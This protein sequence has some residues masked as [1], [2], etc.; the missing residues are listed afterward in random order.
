[1]RRRHGQLGFGDGLVA[2]RRRGKDRLGEIGRLVDW[3]AF[4]DVLS[5]IHASATGAPGYAPLTMFKVLLLQQWYRL[6]DP[7][8]E[9]ALDDRLSFLRFV[10]LS[11]EDAV[12]DHS[13]IS[14]FRSHLIA[15]GL[16]EPLFAE[17][18][19]QLMSHRLIVRKGTLIDASVVQAAAAQPSAKQG[20]R[21]TVDPEAAWARKGNRATFGYKMHIAV[22]RGSLL[23]RRRDLTPGNRNDC[24]PA[25]GLICG[26]EAAVYADKAYD[27]ATLRQALAR[28]NIRNRIMQRGNKHHALPPAA[29]RRN[30]RLSPIRAPV[31]AVFGTLK[32]HYRMARLRYHG[33]VRN[34]L[35]LT[36]ACMAFNLR[37]WAVIAAT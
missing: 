19:R 25:A 30:R 13:T 22:D 15:H 28:R 11:L 14:R 12:P 23:I 9:E 35:A 3:R 20:Q 18:E 31:E 5:P 32:R 34:R 6:S 17:L 7:E 29:H 1:M 4:E 16:M 33:L 24:E 8:M 21:S 36:M 37:R 27:S 26:D 10:G 2:H